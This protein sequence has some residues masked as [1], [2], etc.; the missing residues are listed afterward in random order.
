[1]MR[2]MTYNAATWLGIVLIL[3]LGWLGT[4]A[5]LS[6][7]GSAQKHNS[8]PTSMVRTLESI[9][10]PITI[11]A[12]TR[13]NP[14]LKERIRSALAP[15]QNAHPAIELQWETLAVEGT[16]LDSTAHLLIRTQDRQATVQ[17]LKPDALNR[18]FHQLATGKK[19][20][21]GLLQ[22]GED[23][24]LDNADSGGFARFN[25]ELQKLGYSLYIVNAE[26]PILPDNLDVLLVRSASSPF[27]QTQLE[28]IKYWLGQN[29]PT[30]WLQESTADHE[31]H[32]LMAQ[33]GIRPLPG[34]VVDGEGHYRESVGLRHPAVVA[35]TTYGSHAITESMTGISVFPVSLALATRPIDEWQSTALV[36][37]SEASWNE[38]SEL[39]GKLNL[40]TE[41]ET[42]GPHTLALALENATTHQRIVF[43]GD[44]DFLSN[45][46]L[47]L[48]ANL[49]LITR[50]LTWL[51]GDDLLIDIEHRTIPD[52]RL[53]LSQTALTII[54]LFWLILLPAGFFLLSGRLWYL[55]RHARTTRS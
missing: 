14:E 18:A 5:N 55:R 11:T 13:D 38:T 26:A 34:L 51:S 49:K 28:L 20:W 29:K 23:F 8:L 40:D 2:S 4:Q 54:A 48:G 50:T 22:S 42:A 53:D 21:I 35:T 7:D 41:Q 32:L 25:N 16:S 10:G 45:D 39:S 36:S 17:T 24:P 27:S 37:S 6:F 19:R 52:Q 1:M 15:Y 47:G 33:F 44:S 12:H 30:L 43:V 31:V 3:G 46:Y 9:P